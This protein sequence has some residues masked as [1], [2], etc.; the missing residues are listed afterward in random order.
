[1]NLALCRALA[2]PEL[3]ALSYTW[4]RGPGYFESISHC[5]LEVKL[6]RCV[7]NDVSSAAQTERKGWG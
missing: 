1:M 3:E 2:L 5:L 7:N 4:V 6:L